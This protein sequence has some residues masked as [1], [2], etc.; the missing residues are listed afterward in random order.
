MSADRTKIKICGLSR[1]CDVEYANEAQPDFIGFVI[2]FPKSHR[3]V[4][5]EQAAKLRERLAD[6]ILPVG[7]FV[8]EKPEVVAHLLNNQTIALAQLHGQEEESYLARLRDLTDGK[9][10]K[11][12]KIAST[13]DVK[14]AIHSSADYILLDNG[15]GTGRAFDWRLIGKIE[16]PWFLAGGLTPDNLSDA[17]RDVQPWAVDLSS[18]VELEKYK[19]R[20]KMIAAVRAV[21][22]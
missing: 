8:N 20:E 2:N 21:R 19:D 10:I 3:N 17:I 18:G 1:L 11:A 7:V 5:P 15:T 16:R 13:E 12:F 14:A 4:S 6:S 9:L 22:A